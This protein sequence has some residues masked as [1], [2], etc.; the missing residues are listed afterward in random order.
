MVLLADLP[1][2]DNM[3][4]E[5]DSQIKNIHDRLEFLLSK[6]QDAKKE[7][8]E[9][10]KELVTVRSALGGEKKQLEALQLKM[11]TMETSVEGWSKEDRSLLRGKIEIFLKETEKCLSLLNA[12]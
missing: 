8:E 4:D 1:K 2:I 11:E 7:N 3:S 5:I 6:Y 12:Q 9:L 10:K